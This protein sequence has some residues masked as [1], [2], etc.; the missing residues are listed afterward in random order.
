MFVQN[1]LFGLIVAPWT[2]DSLKKESI[3]VPSQLLLRVLGGKL[4]SADLPAG[5]GF[6]FGSYSFAGQLCSLFLAAIF[7]RVQSSSEEAEAGDLPPDVRSHFWKLH[8]RE[9]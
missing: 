2:N 1:V 4:V 8:Q 6:P 5:D 3:K 7:G 9:F